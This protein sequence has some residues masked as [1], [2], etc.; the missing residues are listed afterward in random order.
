MRPEKTAAL[1]LDNRHSMQPNLAAGGRDTA[2]GAHQRVD[3][4]RQ[5]FANVWSRI[6]VR[7]EPSDDASDAQPPQNM[8]EDH[9]SDDIA[10]AGV[11][12]YNA[13]QLGV[14]AAG[15][16]KIDKGLWRLNLDA[17]ASAN[18]RC[19]PKLVGGDGLEPPTL[20]V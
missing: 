7:L 3:A 8:T 4:G 9:R 18:N 1:G 15:L 14:R 12:K 11:E 19:D 17:A 16:E 10:A 20:S 13:P 2:H 5:A 6:A